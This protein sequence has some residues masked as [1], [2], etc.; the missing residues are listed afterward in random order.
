ERT[1]LAFAV[2]LYMSVYWLAR[3]LIQFFYFDRSDSPQGTFFVFAELILVLLFVY[4]TSV[5]GYAMSVNFSS[6]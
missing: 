5:Y 3:I 6:Y 4:L 2:T 1:T